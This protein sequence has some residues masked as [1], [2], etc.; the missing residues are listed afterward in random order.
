[1]FQICLA[2][3]EKISDHQFVN[4][5]WQTIIEIFYQGHFACVH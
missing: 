3:T 5:G 2:K 1:M 4:F